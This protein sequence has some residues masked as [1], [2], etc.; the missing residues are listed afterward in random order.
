MTISI[1]ILKA[2][3]L[4]QVRRKLTSRHE[5]KNEIKKFKNR[6]I[7]LISF[8]YKVHSLQNKIILYKKSFMQTQKNKVE[9]MAQ[10]TLLW[11]IKHV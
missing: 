9:N 6:F 1:I 5:I 3:F 7:A 10:Q 8:H 4:Y 2:V 11:G